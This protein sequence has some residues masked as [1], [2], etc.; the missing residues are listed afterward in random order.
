MN[1]LVWSCRAVLLAACLV[2]PVL[3]SAEDDTYVGS[4]FG[5]LKVTMKDDGG[6]VGSFNKG[7]KLVTALI[8]DQAGS[9][10]KS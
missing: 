6:L 9:R 5:K 2:A 1:V 8:K 7:G 3:A 10:L 4:S